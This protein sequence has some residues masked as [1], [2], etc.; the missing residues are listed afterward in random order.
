MS[1][2]PIHLLCFVKLQSECLTGLMCAAQYGSVEVV[3]LLLA[4]GADP[5]I[6]NTVSGERVTGV[7][8]CVCSY[9]CI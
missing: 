5:N 2:L 3:R 8:C 4:R 7:D 1:S 9:T 6:Q